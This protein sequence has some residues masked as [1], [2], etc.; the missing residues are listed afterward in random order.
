MKTLDVSDRGG[1]GG[2]GKLWMISVVKQQFPDMSEWEGEAVG[3][4]VLEL[5]G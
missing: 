5:F 1:E 2:E 4:G 3:R